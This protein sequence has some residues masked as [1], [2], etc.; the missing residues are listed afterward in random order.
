MS[1]HQSSQFFWSDWLGDQAVRR[2]TPAE[3]GLWID[4]IALAAVGS[5]T[6]YVCDDRGDPI[7]NEEI[8]RLTNAT[9]TDVVE[10]INGILA[11]GAASRDRT[12]RLFNRRMVRQAELSAKR[13]R[14]GR[15]GGESTALMWQ[16]FQGLPQQRSQQMPGQVPRRR[17][18][19][20][21]QESK[22][23]TSSSVA[24]RVKEESV[25]NLSP[26]GSLATAHPEGAL[27]EPPVAE[28]DPEN[29]LIASL[30]RMAENRKK[31]SQA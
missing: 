1:A 17:V 9:P 8:A 30:N 31:A 12:G 4:L 13:K 21:Y 19:V 24:A 26:G 14:A 18:S 6:G 28:Q 27:R 7:S 25:V 5:P 23:T 2:L 29:P 20:P 16:G 15:K 22:T 3:R 11:K 10:L